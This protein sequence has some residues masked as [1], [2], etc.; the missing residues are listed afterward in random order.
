LVHVATLRVVALSTYLCIK[1]C[2]NEYVAQAVH[3]ETYRESQKQNT[4]LRT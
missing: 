1:N 3:V 2:F 4:K